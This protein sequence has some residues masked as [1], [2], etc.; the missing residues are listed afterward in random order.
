MGVRLGAEVDGLLRGAAQ[1]AADADAFLEERCR[2]QNTKAKVDLY[3]LY[4]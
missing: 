1:R 2:N 3:V 4:L